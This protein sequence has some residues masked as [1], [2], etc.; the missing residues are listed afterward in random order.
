MFAYAL[1]VFL[2]ASIAKDLWVHGDL[3]DL[4]DWQCTKQPKTQFLYYEDQST[5]IDVC[6]RIGKEWLSGRI[7]VKHLGLA[8]SKNNYTDKQKL[9]LLLLSTNTA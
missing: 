9:S 7:L 6:E 2:P 1:T 5:Q 4:H 8:C 3:I